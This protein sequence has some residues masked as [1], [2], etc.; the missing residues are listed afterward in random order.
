MTENTDGYRDSS[1]ERYRM[2][3]GTREKVKSRDHSNVIRRT[4][5]MYHESMC[6]L[7]DWSNSSDNNILLSA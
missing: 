7:I 4:I 3:L 5:Q 2:R 1:R 6:K